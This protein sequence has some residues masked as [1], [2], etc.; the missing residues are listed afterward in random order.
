MT[1]RAV[2]TV[3]QLTEQLRGVVEE[4][5]P[6]VWVEGEISNFRL[7][8]SG[9][10]Y[11]TLKDDGAQLRTVLF[12]NRMRRIRFEPGD[13]QHVLAFG[14]LEV[15]AQ[16]GEYQFVVELLEPRGLARCSSRSSRSRPGSAPRASS[17]RA[18]SDRCLAFRGAS[19][20]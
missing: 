3:S 10:A 17:R 18:A 4:R 12:R 16:R 9:H 15:Y 2:L 5:F 20:S 13:G 1:D 11:F 19:A 6:A 14:S 7:Y 8:G